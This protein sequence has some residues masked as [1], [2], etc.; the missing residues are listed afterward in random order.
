LETVRERIIRALM[1]SDR[2]LTAREIAVEA[3]LGPEG[4]REV[5]EHLVH[6]SRTLAA[7][8]GLRILMEPPYCRKC[9]Y[10]FRDLKRPR[11]PRR[12]PR[13]GSEW[14]EPPRFTVGKG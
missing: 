13:C 4:A 7:R 1:S 3:G 8:T 6:A 12:C 5:Y 11:K 9:G 10:V 14:I 2:P